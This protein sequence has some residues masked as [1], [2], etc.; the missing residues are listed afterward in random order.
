MKNGLRFPY[1][2]RAAIAVA[3]ALAAVTLVQ[4]GHGLIPTP[5]QRPATTV[6]H[7]LDVTT[8][9]QN[10]VLAS[11]PIAYYRLDDTG[12]SALDSSGNG[13][14]GAIGANVT[15]AVAG[16]VP[17]SPDTA[18][19]FPGA[20]SSASIVNVPPNALFKSQSA[21]TIE[22]SLKFTS[23]PALWTVPV[24]YGNDNNYSPYALYFYTNGIL[25]AQF[26]LTTG[27]LIVADPT[28]LQPNTTYMVVATFD[29][30]T[31][32][33]YVNGTLVKSVAKTGTIT[34]FDNTYG[35]GI[36]DDSSFSDPGFAGTIDEVAIYNKALTAAD[37]TAHY[38]A[39]QTGVGPTPTPTPTATPTSTPTPTATATPP[40]TGGYPN[41]VLNSGPI[42][43]YRLDETGAVVLD[44]SPDHLNGSD[45]ANVLKGAAGLI[46][47]SSDTAMLFSGARGAAN[48]V[49]IPPNAA[50]QASSQVT[51]EASLKFSSTPALWSVPV[52]YG[53]DNNY[54]P[55][56]LY[57]YTNGT[58]N[59]QFFLNTGVLLVADPT[60]LQPNTPYLVVA[61][62]DGATGKLYV[63]GAMVGSVAKTGVIT[64]YDNTYG[65][66]I[67]DDSSASDP[68]FA[69]TIDEVAIYNRALTAADVTAHYTAAQSG[70]G[71]PPPTPTPPPVGTYVD[72]ST[73]GYDLARSGNNPNETT[74][75]TG[76]VGTLQPLWSTNLGSTGVTSQPVLA[77]NVTVAG[78]TRNMLYIGSLSGAFA[79]LDADTGAIVWRKTMAVSTY[80]CG[81]SL[82]WSVGGTV[83]FDR[84]QNRVF[85]MDG[86]MQLH[87]FD[88]ATGAEGAGWPVNI[89][90]SPL[91]TSHNLI[92][93]GLT[94]NTSNGILYAETSS[95]CDISP[96]FGQI[97]A[98][99][100]H[101]GARI[102]SFFPAQGQSG[103]SIW[104]FGGASIDNATNDVYIATGNADNIGTPS[105]PQNYGYSEDVV[106]LTPMLGVL[107]ANY[108]N[109]PTVSDADFGATPILYGSSCTAAMNKSGV[110]V[111]YNQ[112][113]IG[114]GP[115]QIIA[116]AP[117]SD[118]GNFIG[119]PAYSPTSNLLYVPVPGDSPD[120]T[121]H[122]GLAALALQGNCTLALAWNQVFGLN[123]ATTNS[124]IPHSA[125][126]VANG[127]VYETDGPGN[128]VYAFNAAS[129][130]P[131]WNSG[132]TVTS[133]VYG[134]PVIDH[135]LYVASFQGIIYAF[136]PGGTASVVRRPVLRH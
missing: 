127:V 21:V 97:D 34:N 58:L 84:T 128:T 69:G 16:L 55:Y 11:G 107:A 108:P 115:T 54:S 37:V 116:M 24:S 103:G 5:P 80:F 92:Y 2:N 32:K 62:F 87:S 98:L 14:S 112:N 29:G 49:V 119:V 109:L 123:S 82:P 101:S 31:G 106:Q 30:T 77:S 4:C 130:A 40:Q 18:M 36:G 134:Q 15:K 95:S 65:L 72:W 66:G 48:I 114:S 90:V 45:G 6:F 64:N 22:A 121:Y 44:S 33:L 125:P 85:V 12:A 61:T 67:G 81:T 118:N 129:G 136:S 126:S 42:A 9:Y 89:P 71:P 63:N 52:S 70:G 100:S 96:W 99:D 59:A 105:I 68:G 39:A 38:T 27:V 131:L 50:F 91:D 7:K 93:A 41:A 26:F 53:N 120:G 8:A 28:P 122:H 135:H 57:F 43:Y 17:T 83:T 111:V 1:V 74:I 113:S 35:L 46:P 88:M 110:L 60:P 56:A 94:L 124:D 13:L 51:I 76:N 104:G 75:S 132:S 102:A 47:T 23:P 25:N 117:P 79:A 133:A 73:F 19:S 3:C 86:N 20:K 10:A 78:G